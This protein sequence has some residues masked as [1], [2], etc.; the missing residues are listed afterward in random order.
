MSKYSELIAGCMTWGVWGKNLNT[1]EMSTL[2]HTCLENDI[3]TFDH[4][5]IYGSFT[6]ESDF[7]KALKE[8]GIDRST[9]QIILL[10]N[11][12]YSF[13]TFIFPGA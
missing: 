10:T 7:G 6:T 2:I 3:T 9:I 12:Q 8:G 4:A 5:D 11:L 13:Y 1:Q